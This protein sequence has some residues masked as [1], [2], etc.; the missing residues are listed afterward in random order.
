M[1]RA[2]VRLL[3]IYLLMINVI[4]FYMYGIDKYKAKKKKWRIPE[5]A[6]LCSS[7]AGGAAGAWLAMSLFHHKTRVPVFRILVPVSFLLWILIAGWIIL[8]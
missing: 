7:F 3:A 5:A 6:L 2:E 4:A 1:E 8:H